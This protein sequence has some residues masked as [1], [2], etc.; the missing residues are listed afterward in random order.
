MEQSWLSSVV[1]PRAARHESL[2]FRPISNALMF[3]AYNV[4]QREHKL[5]LRGKKLQIS[6]R[7]FVMIDLLKGILGKMEVI[8]NELYK[9]KETACRY[10]NP[11]K[12]ITE[13]TQQ[14]SQICSLTTFYAFSPGSKIPRQMFNVCADRQKRNRS[15][16]IPAFLQDWDFKTIAK[17]IKHYRYFLY[18]GRTTIFTIPD[19]TILKQHLP[20][21]CQQF[22]QVIIIINKA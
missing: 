13:K 11:G 21:V 2:L 12:I 5:F 20:H 16:K 10:R 15:A 18:K 7:R 14:F 17:T 3:K 4:T 8:A 9:E 22:Q 6:S 19:K 1:V